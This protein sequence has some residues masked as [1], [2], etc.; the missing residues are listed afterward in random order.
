MTSRR[1]GDPGGPDPVVGNVRHG[2]C[3]PIW[4]HVE[5]SDGRSEVAEAL[6]VATGDPG[7]SRASDS[8]PGPNTLN[9][10]VPNTARARRPPVGGQR[11][12]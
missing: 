5:A 4:L 8:T 12:G 10:P 6:P 3:V 11:D 2:L 7:A 1:G 9:G